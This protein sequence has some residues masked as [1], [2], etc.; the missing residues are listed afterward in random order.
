MMRIQYNSV[1]PGA[2]QSI[3]SLSDFVKN[4]GLESSLKNLVYLRASQLNK[5]AYCVDMHAQDALADGE[6]QQKI[7]CVNVWRESPFFTER[8]RAALEFTERLTDLPAGGI[9][10]E[11]YEK[12]RKV[13]DEHEY[14]ALVMAINT[15]NCWNRLMI[16]CGG[17]SGKYHNLELEKKYPD[18]YYR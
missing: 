9:S 3:N 15:I 16:A 7:N 2:A 4:T 5:C 11:F 14:I 10:D 8:E 6:K 18:F 1:E 17:S 12:I 13:F